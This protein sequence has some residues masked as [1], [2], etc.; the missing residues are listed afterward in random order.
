MTG[1]IGDFTARDLASALGGSMEHCF[2]RTA[3]GKREEVEGLLTL[4]TVPDKAVVGCLCAIEIEDGWCTE[5]PEVRC[6]ENWIRKDIDWHVYSDGSLCW[7]IP[8]RWTHQLYSV[9][10]SNSPKEVCA[11]AAAYLLNSVRSLLARHHIGW[12]LGLVRWPQEWRAWS[13]GDA[14]YSEFEK[15]RSA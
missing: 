9:G 6:F 10:L 2:R 4:Q 12:Q 1:A 11:F 13:H 15:E 7:E 14:G 3:F 5:L 8:P